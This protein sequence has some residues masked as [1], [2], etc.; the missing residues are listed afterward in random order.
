[1]TTSSPDGQYLSDAVAT[2]S[3]WSDCIDVIEWVGC[4]RESIITGCKGTGRRPCL[5]F[6]AIFGHSIHAVY[7][8]SMLT[9]FYLI[10]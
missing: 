1:M 4:L 10:I 7:V 3:L 6:Y 9:Y 8:H 5:V 2:N